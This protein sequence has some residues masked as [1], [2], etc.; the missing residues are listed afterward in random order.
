MLFLTKQ[1]PDHQPPPQA[2][3]SPPQLCTSGTADTEFRTCSA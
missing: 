1:S 3:P 2:K